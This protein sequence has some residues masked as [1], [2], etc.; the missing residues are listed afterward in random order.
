MAKISVGVLGATGVVGQNYLRLLENHPWF[1]V[2]HLVASEKSAGKSYEEAVAGRWRMASAIPERLRGLRVCSLDDLA[3]ASNNCQLV[4]SALDADVARVYEQR[5]AAAG[6]PVVSNSSAHR[7]DSDVP[8]ILPEINADHLEIIPAQQRL[9]GFGKGFIV[10]KPNCSVQSYLTPLYSLHEEFGLRKAIVTTM[11]A[12]SGAGYPGVASLDI[13]GNVVPFIKGEEEK[14]ELE[15]LKILGRVEGERI[16]PCNEI[17]FSA[18]CNRVPVV[19][20]HLACVSAEFAEK[21]SADQIVN[22]W[23]TFE[24][25]PQ[26]LKLPSAPSPAIV[27]CEEPDRPQPRLDREIGNGMTVTVGR[28]RACGV[29]QWKFVGLSHNTVRGAAGGG[30]LNAEL[31]RARGLLE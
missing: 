29:L 1:E 22:A 20:G 30:I 15:P 9:R 21:P 23:N 27:Y 4:F 28:L 24:G 26:Q 2:T 16:L 19:D 10:V 8:M 11:Q 25:V 13:L 17:I 14:S 18:H 3:T 31:L 6:F 12:V 7:G 5:Y